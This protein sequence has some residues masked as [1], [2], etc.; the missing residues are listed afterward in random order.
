MTGDLIA[1]HRRPLTDVD[2]GRAN[3]TGNHVLARVAKLTPLG[4]PSCQCSFVVSERQVS[5]MLNE[6]L[7]WI[8]SAVDRPQI[9]LP[10]RVPGGL[11]NICAGQCEKP[12]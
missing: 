2:P 4:S 11:E 6:G 8:R 10:E 3:S 7:N 1:G 12:Q 5:S 9:R